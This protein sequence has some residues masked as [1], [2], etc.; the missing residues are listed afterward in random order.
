[1]WR[2]KISGGVIKRTEAFVMAET[3]SGDRISR[4]WLA[5]ELAERSRAG[6][7]IG[8]VS[9]NRI[10]EDDRLPSGLVGL[11]LLA[12]GF[13]EVERRLP[14]ASELVPVIFAQTRAAGL[15]LRG[16]LSEGAERVDI[17]L[18]DSLAAADPKSALAI[19]CS[20]TVEGLVSSEVVA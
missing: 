9:V 13:G 3:G 11:R 4:V 7:F 2:T 1:M 10:I 20:R 19:P 15:L 18:A 16:I 12:V 6:K 14:G 8:V 17:W 5:G